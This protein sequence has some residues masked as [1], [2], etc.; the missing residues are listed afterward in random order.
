MAYGNLNFTTQQINDILG[1]NIEIINAKYIYIH[2]KNNAGTG[3][4]DSDGSNMFFVVSGITPLVLKPTEI[5]SALSKAGQIDFGTS[6]VPWKNGYFSAT[7]SCKTLNQTSDMTMK[8]KIRDI[9]VSVSDIANAPS[10]CFSW[11]DT[12]EISAGSSAQYWEKILPECVQKENG[13][14]QMAYGNIALISVISLAKKVEKLETQLLA[15]QK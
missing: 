10:F 15:L 3:Y 8:E 9:N 2:G 7:L 12:K 13:K 1:G 4:I 6:S 14:L 11:K 5:R